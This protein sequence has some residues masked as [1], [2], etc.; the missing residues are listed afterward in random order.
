VKHLENDLYFAIPHKSKGL[1]W[2]KLFSAYSLSLGASCFIVLTL[3][4]GRT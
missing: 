2:C 1:Q 3:A 4:K